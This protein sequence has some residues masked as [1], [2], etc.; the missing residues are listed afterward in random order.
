MTTAGTPTRKGMASFLGVLASKQ[1]HRNLVYHL[2]GLPLATLYFTIIV[3]GICVGLSM[4]VVAL[5]GVPI[6]IGLWYLI[7][8]FAEIERL[9]ANGLLATEIPSAVSR[10][11]PPGMLRRIRSVWMDPRSWS[12]LSYLLLRFP[13]G[14]AAFVVTVTLIPVSIGLILSPVAAWADGTISWG[15]R[16]LDPFPWPLILTPLGF[17]ALVASLTMTNKVAAANGRWAKAS[18]GDDLEPD[19]GS[20]ASSTKPATRTRIR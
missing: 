13:A 16:A 15:G 2:L 19:H 12:T 14:I 7:R 17:V 6:L 3:T 9:L 20:P 18:L 1:T 10:E 11:H 4:L 8:V 5:L